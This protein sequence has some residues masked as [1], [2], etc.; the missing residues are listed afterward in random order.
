MSTVIV[1]LVPD[2]V[3]VIGL[4]IATASVIA[5]STTTPSPG[6]RFAKVYRIINILALNICK[7][8]S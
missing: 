2:W 7:A 3:E 6:C 1:S 5:A 8:K 4:I